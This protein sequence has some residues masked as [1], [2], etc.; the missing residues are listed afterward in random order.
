MDHPT[1]P[2]VRRMLASLG[3]I[4]A[5]TTEILLLAR[6]RISIFD[7]ALTRA[8]DA[9]ARVEWLRQFCLRSRRNELHLVLHDAAS[10]PR[11]CPR[12]ASLLGRFDHVIAVRETRPEAPHAQDP[13]V[14][15]DGRHFVHRF[16]FDAARAGVGINDPEG[17]APLAARFAEIWDAGDPSS[18]S[19]T[20]GL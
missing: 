4:D 5:A 3:E 18:Q 1:D 12:L 2:V 16:H 7:R 8:W 10:L 19:T 15:V 9:P 6:H 14:L 11:H 13:L 17:A 20:L